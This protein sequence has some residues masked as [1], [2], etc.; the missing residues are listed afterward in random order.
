M[1]FLFTF[2]L[3][4]MAVPSV[5]ATLG[6][7]IGAGVRTAVDQ[8]TSKDVTFEAVAN[9]LG[10]PHNT[11]RA[12]N[13]GHS[14]NSSFGSLSADRMA[15]A[16][17]HGATD[18]A[19][20]ASQAAASVTATVNAAVP[21]HQQAFVSF[22]STMASTASA[23]RGQAPPDA[24]TL[25]SAANA[26]SFA[27]QAS[28]L[29]FDA[30]SSDGVG[31]APTL[32]SPSRV[33]DA[34]TPQQQTVVGLAARK[35]PPHVALTPS[36]STM[37]H[38]RLYDA[39]SQD[40]DDDDEDDDAF[41]ARRDGS[42]ADES[43]ASPASPSSSPVATSGAFYSI[44][45]GALSRWYI[46][47]A[48]IAVGA[49][50]MTPEDAL[51]PLHQF[52]AFLHV[53]SFGTEQ[54]WHKD[55][56]AVLARM[57]IHHRLALAS[58]AVL[59]GGALAT[60]VWIS[61]R[62]R[63]DGPVPAGS[64]LGLPAAVARSA[65]FHSP[66][67][68]QPIRATTTAVRLASVAV[69]VVLF[70]EVIS[71]VGE[72]LRYSSNLDSFQR[73]QGGEWA[74][75]AA[76]LAVHREVQLRALNCAWEWMA[77]YIVVPVCLT[78]VL[79]RL[80][81]KQPPSPASSSVA[82]APSSSS[83]SSSDSS[84]SSSFPAFF[85]RFL[86][87]RLAFVHLGAWRLVRVVVARATASLAATLMASDALRRSS[88]SSS[89]VDSTRSGGSASLTAATWTAEALTADMLSWIS[90]ITDVGATTHHATPLG[91]ANGPPRLS[92]RISSSIAVVTPFVIAGIVNL[93]KSGVGTSSSTTASAAGGGGTS[94]QAPLD[95]IGMALNLDAASSPLTASDASPSGSP[96]IVVATAAGGEPVSTAT[97]G[98]RI[99]LFYAF[100]FSA[101]YTVV[102]GSHVVELLLLWVLS[103]TTLLWLPAAI[104]MMST[105]F[106]V[107]AGAGASLLVWSYRPL[108][109]ASALSAGVAL[110]C[111]VLV[112]SAIWRLLDVVV[113][114]QLHLARRGWRRTAPQRIQSIVGGL[115]AAIMWAVP[116]VAFLGCTAS[117]VAAITVEDAAGRPW[118]S[119]VL[120]WMLTPA[121]SPVV[122]LDRFDGDGD[123]GGAAAAAASLGG[124][125]LLLPFEGAALIQP[126]PP[127]LWLAVGLVAAL[128]AAAFVATACERTVGD[129][130]A[131]GVE[132]GT[133]RRQIART[134]KP[135][136]A[137]RLA[138][139]VLRSAVW[140]AMVVASTI[141]G[142]TA[143]WVLP[144]ASQMH[145]DVW[146]LITAL[147]V[148]CSLGAFAGVEPQL[149]RV[150]LCAAF[151]T[152]DRT[153][154]LHGGGLP[155]ETR[156]DR[157][158]DFS[159]HPSVGLPT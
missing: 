39:D 143:A 43:G 6:T 5:A 52:V 133:L 10:V 71:S 137:R 78:V 77:E 79:S 30:A 31:S 134:L 150:L 65:T 73:P 81:C 100:A 37:D 109:L 92:F 98:A 112:A 82:A 102:L 42:F 108:W 58:L 89:V 19:E 9:R 22:G 149:T 86:W 88:S 74:S 62:V 68:G 63:W 48:S 25:F 56:V 94:S 106:A 152:D 29:V 45:V 121:S 11:R 24:S 12:S 151:G 124:G 120:T 46:A 28:T 4:F 59:L 157:H 15:T 61:Q 135:F 131:A 113:R 97:H 145:G 2:V 26:S 54:L 110:S 76:T 158:R 107:F 139:S 153:R 35:S 69:T 49:L 148:C 66:V 127:V 51:R 18:A 103:F 47:F 83:S 154:H 101:V 136:R 75:A 111:G 95:E 8:A 87:V 90:W 36:P 117:A 91:P 20:A 40:D 70:S 33:M 99:L 17:A 13:G 1:R 60:I 156:G 96:L 118:I 38:R 41:G 141:V 132:I 34:F 93:V 14:R 116:W 140:L 105:T 55:Y 7:A 129:A 144:L 44:G 32:K 122:S 138:A 85:R 84:S 147:F 53:G 119:R 16:I 159:F 128:V 21:S 142:S 23:L 67:L 57:T 115:L 126:Q 80:V 155:D 72:S 125:S 130:R 104:A 3:R 64:V 27:R 114:R 50:F 146:R 123:D